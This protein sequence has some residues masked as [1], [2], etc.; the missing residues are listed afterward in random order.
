[1]SSVIDEEVKKEPEVKEPPAI[2]D[3]RGEPVRAEVIA[4]VKKDPLYRRP[5]FLIAAILIFLVGALLGVRYWL[6]AR[7]H[8]TTDDAF[9][10][11]HITQV[12]PKVSGY[13]VK[14]YVDSNQQVNQ[15]DLL[16]EIDP[17]DFQAKLDQAKA[18]LAAGEARLKEARSGVTLTR[19]N[20]KANVQQAA[21]SVQHARAG[22]AASQAQAAA[23]R[24]RVS[25]AGATID[26]ARAN[27]QQARAQ[28]SATEA[29]VVRAQAD[30]ARYQQLFGK[31]EVSRQ[32]LD[33]AIATART[34]EAQVRAA[35]ERVSAAAAQVEEMQASRSAAG[36]NAHKA[37]S[38]VGAAEAQVNEALGRLAQANTGP[39]QIAVS[40]AQA[41]TA[42]ASIAQLQAAVAQ[43][44]LELSY[45]KIYAPETGRVTHK[46]VEQGA[47]IQVGQP[48]MAIVPGDVWVT[49]NFKE[50]QIGRIR[51]GQ[52]VD[53]YVDA[54]PGKVFK[55][56]V[57]SI[58]AGTGAQFSLLPPENATGNYVKVV[59]R[60]PAKIVF[61]EPPDPNHI[62]APGMSVEPEV[63]VP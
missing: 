63:K 28:L 53:I 55:G 59:Q 27:L 24:S 37:Q 52:P 8:E 54:F 31:D 51:P 58:Q 56:R 45:T 7:S 3:E 6:Y 29:E 26:T 20:T 38:E 33:Q 2:L 5:A 1:M 42:G 30:V 57:D 15:G 35:Q 46:S 23:D 12:S 50:S 18:A 10:D 48:L 22:V 4:G 49:A 36:E 16:A 44:E 34:A 61:I 25:Q 9:I 14:L 21:A 40:E 62:L 13:V 32:Q 11:A 17:R 39:Q 41:Q 43:A 19:A 47:L 60:L